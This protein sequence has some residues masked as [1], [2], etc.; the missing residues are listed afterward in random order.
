[1]KFA[2]PGV[3]RWFRRSL[4]AAE[5]MRYYWDTIEQCVPPATIM[6]ALTDASLLQV[7]REARF[8]MLSEYTA[9]RAS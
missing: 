1:M 7:S 3:T 2:V 8:G 5:L 4:D 6:T 9:T